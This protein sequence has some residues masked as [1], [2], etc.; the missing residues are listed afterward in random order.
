LKVNFVYLSCLCED[1]GNNCCKGELLFKLL[2]DYCCFILLLLRSS[3]ADLGF[4]LLKVGGDGSISTAGSSPDETPT[5][6]QIQYLD[7]VC[8]TT[9]A[10][11]DYALK[12]L[13]PT[14][15]PT[16]EPTANPSYVPTDSPVVAPSVSPSFVPTAGKVVDTDAPT[17][18]E[19]TDSPV[20]STDAP[21]GSS[22]PNLSPGPTPANGNVIPPTSSTGEPT[23]A[24]FSPSFTNPP[25][26]APS[27][28]DRAIGG[29]SEDNTT[30]T[31][32]SSGGIAG[33]VIAS[34]A[35]IAAG[36]IVS[37]KRTRN[38]EDPSLEFKGDKDLEMGDL[39][40]GPD[41]GPS[42]TNADVDS[43]SS[44]PDIVPPS[45]DRLNTLQ[46]SPPLSPAFAA[47]PYSPERLDLD[48]DDDSS[49]SAGQSGWSSSQGL[50][51]LNTASFDAG[52]DGS[53]LSGGAAGRQMAGGSALAAIGVASAVTYNTVKKSSP[54][55]K[56]VKQRY[57]DDNDDDGSISSEEGMAAAVSRK[58]LDAAI[59]G[60]S[61][62]FYIHFVI[63]HSLTY[64]FLYPSRRLGCCRSNCCFACSHH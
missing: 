50:S 47:G 26:M 40:D 55:Q 38:E 23:V 49:S 9:Q 13:P 8:S 7:T 4:Y 44:A 15:Q 21:F 54:P 34:V 45:P 35:V 30:T 14:L 5:E 43:T 1:G 33:I 27:M 60:I 58:D 46:L 57:G 64:H 11:I 24:T 3:V 6:S 16:E 17:Y 31:T 39:G 32:L 10:S 59:E 56:M 62:C 36:I 19:R 61:N 37:R 51:S 25:S 63:L 53:M 52:E 29:G 12:E 48:S 20:L 22:A 42:P 2:V 28:T 18:M 41:P